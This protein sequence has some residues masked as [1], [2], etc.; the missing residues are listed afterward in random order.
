MAVNVSLN[1]VSYSIPQT[2]NKNWGTAVTS[3]LVAL[4]SGVLS[5]AGGNFTLTADANFGATYGLVSS[6]FTS[7]TANAA[8]TGAV[9]LAAA[10]AVKWR[11]AANLGDVALGV[12]SDRLQWAG[13]DLVDLSTA[14][15]LSNKTFV[16]PALG[17]PASGN[18][19]NCTAFP[20][21]ALGG[22]GT[23]VAT[24]L[25][26]PSSANLA[27]AVTDETGTGALVFASS[28]TL[29]T[30]ALGT[31]SA[32]VLT[33][34]TGLP[35]STGVT[36]TLPIG[37]GGTGQVTANAA[38]NALLPSQASAAGMVLTSDGTNTSW[39][40]PLVNPMDAAG[41]LIYGGALGAA[42]KLAA[43]SSGQFLVSGGTGAP[44]WT[45]TIA[46]LTTFSAGLK[47]SASSSTLDAFTTLTSVTH[48]AAN[49]TASTGTWT[50]ESGDQKAFKYA[51]INKLMIVQFNVQGTDVSSTPN[52]LSVPIPA[53]KTAAVDAGGALN[54]LDANAST[55]TQ[56]HW[57]V[58]GG[59]STIRFYKANTAGGTWSTASG[60][61]GVVGTFAFEIT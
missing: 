8:A 27:A 39:T 53:S 1:G 57:Y 44:S 9:R 58:G 56:G 40:A 28:P 45:N 16:T 3:Y 30:P 37:N 23:G 19:S 55:F 34:G 54:I 36:G 10:D 48:N 7:R 59:G 29:T 41:Q 6:Y 12:A 60:N 31:P 15:T 38:L 52:Y 25:A 61:T 51:I 43:G 32:V 11:N 20:A 26:T 49:F 14:Q 46:N 5:K 42:T 35:L 4:A 13:V 50:V 18:L 22:L 24:F 33:N 47:P 17:T 21:S 2:G